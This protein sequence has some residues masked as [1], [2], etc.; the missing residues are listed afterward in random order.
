MVI[1]TQKT[2]RNVYD[3]RLLYFDSVKHIVQHSDAFKF[4]K[5]LLQSYQ[6]QIFLREPKMYAQYA[7]TYSRQQKH[8]HKHRNVQT[9]QDDTFCHTQYAVF[10]VDVGQMMMKI[11]LLIIRKMAGLCLLHQFNYHILPIFFR[12][13]ILFYMTMVNVG[14]KAFWLGPELLTI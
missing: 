11:I 10:H 4:P 3:L 12:W 8:I 7:H 9:Y 5:W 14:L 1:V 13:Y 6:G 2:E